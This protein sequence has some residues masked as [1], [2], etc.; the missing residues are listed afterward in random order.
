MTP[1]K[2]SAARS[3]RTGFGCR[4]TRKIATLK[5]ISNDPGEHGRL[6]SVTTRL[7]VLW[8]EY[9]SSQQEFLGLITENEVEAEQVTFIEMEETYKAAIDEAKRIICKFKPEESWNAERAIQL[10]TRRR[11]LYEQIRETL[12]HV[13]K[14]LEKVEFMQSRRSLGIQR[15]LLI[16]AKLR[17]QEAKELSKELLDHHIDDWLDEKLTQ[18]L[19]LIADLEVSIAPQQQ[20]GGGAARPSADHLTFEKPKPPNQAEVTEVES[21]RE[22]FYERK[23]ALAVEDEAALTKR[24]QIIQRRRGQALLSLPLTSRCQPA[25]LAEERLLH[26]QGRQEGFEGLDPHS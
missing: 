8:Q 2:L 26:N 24:V 25:S 15:E 4:V 23:D 6:V 22:T 11:G 9:E 18:M 20:E 12:D 17:M 10:A 13:R 1:T 21:T 14:E 3:R 5:T 16:D 7:A 19:T